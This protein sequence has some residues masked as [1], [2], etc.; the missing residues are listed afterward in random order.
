MAGR[1][2]DDFDE[3]STACCERMRSTCG[4]EGREDMSRRWVEAVSIEIRKG[5][6]A[7]IAA[8]LAPRGSRA[9]VPNRYHRPDP[10]RNLFTLHYH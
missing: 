8:A 10:Q 5:V 3:D 9:R 2:G 6:R 4:I 7:Y 1:D